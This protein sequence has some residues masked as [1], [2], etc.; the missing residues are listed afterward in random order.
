VLICLCILL[1]NL[2]GDY[3]LWGSTHVFFGF[4]VFLLWEYYENF[5]GR[6]IPSQL[7]DPKFPVE[8]IIFLPLF[9]EQVKKRG[10]DNKRIEFSDH[11]DYFRDR[12]L[13]TQ[14]N[15][16]WCCQENNRF[17]FLLNLN[18]Y[19]VRGYFGVLRLTFRCVEGEFPPHY[20]AILWTP[21]GCPTIQNSSDANCLELA[22]TSQVKGSFPQHSLHLKCQP[23]GQAT[24]I[25]TNHKVL[26]DSHNPL[27]RFSNLLEWLTKLR[28]GL[29]LPLLVYYASYNSGT[30][31]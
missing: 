31:K 24:S 16:H 28:E 10:L 9:Q 12:Q 13:V 30:A 7:L 3:F 2:C 26:G 29:Y 20:Q 11:C 27:P 6:T 25:L 17:S 22:Q 19:K 21:A 14:W 1:P 5:L 18:W 23:Q 15:L 8:L 4:L